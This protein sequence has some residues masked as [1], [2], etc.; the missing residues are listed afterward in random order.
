[1]IAALMAREY[2][3][4]WR[5]YLAAEPSLT[6]AYYAAACENNGLIGYT[7]VD[8]EIAEHLGEIMSGEMNY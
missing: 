7:Y 8:M 2:G 5:E 6:N 1:M 3:W 4:S